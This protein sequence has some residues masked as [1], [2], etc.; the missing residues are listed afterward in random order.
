MEISFSPFTL[1]SFTYYFPFIFF[2]HFILSF[3]SL[4]SLYRFIYAFLPSF[5][6]TRTGLILKSYSKWCHVIRRGRELG[7]A[8]TFLPASADLR[9]APPSSPHLLPRKRQR[10]RVTRSG[11]RLPSPRPRAAPPLPD[12]D[13]LSAFICIFLPLFPAGGQS[14][15]GARRWCWA[16]LGLQLQLPQVPERAGAA[17]GAARI[18]V[19]APDPPPVSALLSRLGQA[20]KARTKKA[21]WEGPLEP[22]LPAVV[23]NY[24][25]Q[26]GLRG[27]CVFQKLPLRAQPALHREYPEPVPARPGALHLLRCSLASLPGQRPL[28][29][30][31]APF[32]S[33]HAVRAPGLA[34]CPHW[35]PGASACRSLFPSFIVKLPSFWLA[36]RVSA[37][38]LYPAP[39]PTALFFSYLTRPSHFSLLQLPNPSG[40]GLEAGE[41]PRD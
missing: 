5:T 9:R 21:V 36:G 18:A 20:P 25:L 14:A 26:D 35:R 33:S 3:K 31:R 8:V 39:S 6:Q 32:A 7:S 13:W 22:H 40:T 24:R 17:A 30:S 28:T 16:G 34:I 23:G 29:S 37:T 19:Q 15:R 27:L 38:L 11:L 41:P 2:L 4:T 1:Y 10:G 12:P